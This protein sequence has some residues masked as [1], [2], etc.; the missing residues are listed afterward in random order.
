MPI[1]ILG[2]GISGLTAAINLKKAGFD[3]EVHER[4][5]YC[6]KQAKDFQFLENWTSNEDVLDTLRAMHIETEFYVKPWYSQEILS[7]TLKQYIGTSTQPLMYLVKRGQREDSIDKALE[8]QTRKSKIKIVYNSNL[9][10]KEADIIATGMRRPTLVVTGIIFRL[11]QPD[12]SM[13]LLDNNLSYRC[14]SYF[15]VND[16]RGEI[17]CG[18]PKGFNGYGDRLELTVK[19]FEKILHTKIDDIEE[20]FTSVVN[21]GFLNKAKVRGQYFV[22]EAAGFQDHLAGFGMVYA[23]KSGYYAARSIAESTDYDRLWREGFHKPLKISSRNRWIYDRL[24]NDDFEKFV[25]ILR[26]SNSA[27]RYLRGGDDMQSIMR[28]LYGTPL[29]L[30]HAYFMGR[31]IMRSFDIRRTRGS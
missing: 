26:S 9:Q 13:V 20:R 7:P 12:K 23:F 29:S 19:E 30:F 17:A 28:T 21:L 27:I 8:E 31:T 6:G 4:K 25:D 22:G 18:N 2:G 3:V 11:K 16:H 10:Q 1:K 5:D 24:S 15:I 14:Y